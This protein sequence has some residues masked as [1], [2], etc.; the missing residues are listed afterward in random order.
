APA[1]GGALDEGLARRLILVCAPDGSGKTA[2]LA[3]WAPSGNRPVAWLSLDAADNDPV[4]LWRHLVAALDR[5][6]PGIAERVG[7]LLGPPAPPSFEG[8]VTALINELAARP[9]DG[10]VL[11]V[12]DDY[13]LIDAQPVHVS[14]GFLLEHLPPGL[15]LVLASRADPPLPLAR[16]RAG[17]QLAELRAADLRFT[18]AE[19]AALLRESAGADLPAA[20]V[21]ALAARTEGWV[22]GLQLAALSLRGRA[23]PAGFVAAFSG[24]HRYVLDYLAEEVLDR[25]QEELRTFLLET[26]LLERLSG[27][28]C[29]AVTGRTDS[30]AMLEQVERANLFLVPLD[31]VRGWWRYHHLFADL[32]RARLQQQRPGRVAGLHRAAAA[33]C[34]E[35]GLADDAVR[36]ALAAGDAA[37]AARLIERH[38]DETFWPGERAMVQ[39]WLAALP[40]D[41]AGSRPRLCLVRALLAVAGGDA[42]GAGLLLDAAERASA[43]AEDEPFEPSV[44]KAASLFVNVPA[45]IALGRASLAELR[46]DADGTAA[47]ASQTLAK[48]GE[49]ESMLDSTARW[50]LAMAEWLRGRVVEAE[51]GFA[52]GITGWRAA[53]ERYSAAF[54]CHHLGQVQRARG[55][56]DAAVGTYQQ[57]LEITAAPG[58]PAMPAAGIAFVGMGEVAYQRNELEAAVRQISEGIERCRQLTYTQPLATGLAALAWIRQAQGDHAGALQTMSEAGRVAPGPAV[59]GLLNPVPAQRARLQLAQGEVAAAARWVEERGL[60][61][62]DDPGYPREPEYLVLARVLLAQDRA[63]PAL[64]LLGRLHAAAA[65]QGRPGSVIEIQ[66]LQALALAAAGDENAAVDTL[67]QA[68]MLGCSQGYVRV[69]ADEG[70]PMAALLGRLVAAQKADHDVARGVP[71]GCLARLLRAFGEP[72]AAAG[73][74]QHAAAAVPGLVEQLT[75]R[76]LEILALLAAGTPNPRIAEQLVVSLDTVKKH[77]SHLLGKLGAANRTEA[78]TRARELGLIP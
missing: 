66:A 10:E 74:R 14:L 43:D 63:G 64:T 26:S 13:H 29:D 72:P 19:A 38:F 56:L 57:A 39:R 71:L 76:E 75:P 69:F 12:L 42:E 22:A 6:R 30:Q 18:A 9:G 44:G 51:Q 5:A 36:H 41:L 33:W 31:E 65:A 34:E 49:G 28:L 15:H 35:H 46:G 59:A 40:A 54:A 61:P 11:L 17:G 4:R 2:L 68:L 55:R 47:F 16:L 70:A 8:L 32:L 53:G 62:D 67:A 21:A 3:G 52:A 45:A 77:V 23:D 20:A 1:A 27:G 58:R 25:Q 7:P 24:S 37:W 78:V 73:A 50:L 48:T 60:G